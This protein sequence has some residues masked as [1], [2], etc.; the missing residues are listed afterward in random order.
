M[1]FLLAGSLTAPSLSL[2]HISDSHADGK[3][4]AILVHQSASLASN[5][6]HL[7]LNI[8]WWRWVD[9]NHWQMPYEDTALTTVL[10]RHYLEPKVGDDPTTYCLLSNCS[11]N[12]SYSGTAEMKALSSLDFPTELRRLHRTGISCLCFEPLASALELSY[13]LAPW[14][15][16]M[17]GFEPPT[18][19]PWM[20]RLCH[21]GYIGWL[22]LLGSNQLYFCFRDRCHNQ[23]GE[24]AS[25][26]KWT[27]LCLVC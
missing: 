20:M 9:L 23:L 13:S 16:P 8:Y 10:H 17:G 18:S 27:I 4:S 22:L 12:V 5:M 15:V 1:L 2:N 19:S 21:L 25:N 24:G 7:N 3:E 26:N 6:N 14:M 11:A